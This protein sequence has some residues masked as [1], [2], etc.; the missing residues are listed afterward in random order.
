[1]QG[2][3]LRGKKILVYDEQGAGDA[4]QFA[5]YLPYLSER[6]GKVILGCHPSLLRLMKSIKGVDKI[7]TRPDEEPFDIHCSL[8]SLPSAF[9]TTLRSIPAQFP[10]IQADA[11]QSEKWRARIEANS[12]AS[13]ARLKIG[14]TWAGRPQHPN[15][16]NRSI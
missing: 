13:G 16:H 1:W 11:Q 15:D 5:R 4:I 3:E 14:L 8:M 2:E 10:Y 6:G 7:V 12:F 9:Q